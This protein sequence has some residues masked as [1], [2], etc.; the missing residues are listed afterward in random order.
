MEKCELITTVLVNKNWRWFSRFTSL[1]YEWMLFKA[2]WTLNVYNVSSLKQQS[3][4]RYVSPL[5][6][7]ADSKSTSLCSYSLMLRKLYTDSQSS[8]L[9]CSCLMM[10]DCL[11][12]KKQIPLYSLCFDLGA[13][14]RTTALEVSTLTITPPVRFLVIC[15]FLEFLFRQI[16]KLFQSFSSIRIELI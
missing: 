12:A 7:I 2:N 8:S 14:P 4:D 16:W 3:T 15:H 1:I 6:Y 10:H 5:R 13:N 11:H 9:C